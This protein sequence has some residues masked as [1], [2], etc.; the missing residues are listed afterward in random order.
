MMGEKVARWFDHQGQ[1]IEAPWVEG[2]AT[3]YRWDDQRTHAVF[4][5]QS[6]VAV[7]QALTVC[8]LRALEIPGRGAVNCP[9][10]LELLEGST[11]ITSGG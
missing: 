8:G 10:C 2:R 4:G 9:A 5:R 11:P 6:E 1:V 7:H 3:A